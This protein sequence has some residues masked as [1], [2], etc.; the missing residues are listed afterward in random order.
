[1]NASFQPQSVQTGSCKDKRTVLA[2]I[3]FA[4][5]GLYI[6]AYRLNVGLGKESLELNPTAC[7]GASDRLG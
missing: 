1:M 5:A 6:T 2:F 4:Q 3:Q 7:A